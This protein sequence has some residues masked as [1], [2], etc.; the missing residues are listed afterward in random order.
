LVPGP[1]MCQQACYADSC[2]TLFRFEEADG[3]RLESL[4][5]EDQ[6]MLAMLREQNPEVPE[7]EFG[8]FV[9]GSSDAPSIVFDRRE[10]AV[11]T[12]ADDGSYV[13]GARRLEQG[14]AQGN[15]AFSVVDA[16]TEG[17]GG[18]RLL[19]WV[20][21]QAWATNT[22]WCGAGTDRISTPCPQEGDYDYQADKSCRQHDHSAISEK[23]W[24]GFR[25][26]CDSDKDLDDTADNGFVSAVF[27]K[28]GLA[29]AWGCIDWGKY[30]C[31]NW[32]KWYPRYG[33]YCSGQFN[34]YGWGRFDRVGQRRR[35][36]FEF[37]YRPRDK[38][39]PDTDGDYFPRGQQCS[40]DSP[41]LDY[42]CKC[43]V[44][45]T[46]TDVC[47]TRSSDC[48]R[49]KID[50]SA[51]AVDPGS[52]K[53]ACCTGQ[54]QGQGRGQGQG[55]GHGQNCVLCDCGDEQCDIPAW[56]NRCS[57]PSGCTKCNACDC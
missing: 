54:G 25:F 36:S 17:P 37:G 46:S 1:L 12:L 56:A 34:R 24:V 42:E 2:G 27:G 14:V 13:W 23:H 21:F 7:A 43:I 49:C 38:T 35:Q 3:L 32:G 6:T 11:V 4:C 5:V 15:A 40:P 29:A 47:A 10:A 18:R 45:G 53:P 16:R 57:R 28:Y 8:L 33:E 22:N 41:G 26:G 52:S 19:S 30:N 55:Q 51:C 48:R 44:P 31:W 20:E 9:G 39:C 50:P